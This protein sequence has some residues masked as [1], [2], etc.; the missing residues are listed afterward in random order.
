M[1]K[2]LKALAQSRPFHNLSEETLR[3]II[4][5]LRGSVKFFEKGALL[6]DEGEYIDYI[7]IILSGKL[8]VSNFYSTGD[9]SLVNKLE[10][11]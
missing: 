3:E 8:A 7:G 2:I 5:L 11:S 1:D 4:P 10:P 9:E 6:I